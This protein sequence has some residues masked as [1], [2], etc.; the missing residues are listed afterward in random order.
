[1]SSTVAERK[2]NA[3]LIYARLNPAVRPRALYPSYSS[4]GTPTWRATW[5]MTSSGN[6]SSG[7][8]NRA[9][10]G[11]QSQ[12]NSETEACRAFLLAGEKRVLVGS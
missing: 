5:A 12:R 8:G 1:M 6:S 4:A 3:S 10:V 11:E 2:P 7:S 9:F